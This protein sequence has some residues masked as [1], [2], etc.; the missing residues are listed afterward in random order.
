MLTRDLSYRYYVFANGK[1]IFWYY[2]LVKLRR[3]LILYGDIGE[4]QIVQVAT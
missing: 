1:F 4:I 3:D 2:N